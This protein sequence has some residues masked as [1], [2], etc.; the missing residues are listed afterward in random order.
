[1]WRFRD[2]WQQEAG[3]ARALPGV[4]RVVTQNLWFDSH[5]REVRLQGHLRQW[6][7]LD[8]NMVMQEATLACLR[9]LLESDWLRTHYWTTASPDSPAAWQ[10][11]VVFSKHRARRTS[12][13]TLPGSMGRRLLNVEFDDLHLGVVHLESTRGAAEVRREQL[14]TVFATLEASSSALLAGDFNLCSSSSENQHL[15]PDYLESLA[16]PAPP[17]GRPDPG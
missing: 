10:G 9:P 3:E 16:H 14:G 6:Q 17:G 5:Q 7:E 4:L 2:G 12:M 8:P 13:T 11:V 15:A 1:M